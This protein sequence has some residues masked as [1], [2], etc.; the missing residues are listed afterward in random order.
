MRA[1]EIATPGQAVFDRYEPRSE[2]HGHKARPTGRLA[3]LTGLVNVP[4][5]L[6]SVV[7]VASAV[8]T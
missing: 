1:A 7:L 3:Q 6:A 4:L 2:T 5:A 8:A